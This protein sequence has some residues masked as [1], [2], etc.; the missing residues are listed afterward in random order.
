MA[1]KEINERRRGLLKRVLESKTLNRT[2]KTVVLSA[3]LSGKAMSSKAVEPQVKDAAVD[4]VEQKTEAMPSQRLSEN[5]A[6]LQKFADFPELSPAQAAFVDHT[7]IVDHDLWIERDSIAVKCVDS[8]YVQDLSLTDVACARECKALPKSEQSADGYISFRRDPGVIGSDGKSTYNGIISTDFNA[9]KQSIVLMY[10]SNNEQVAALGRQMINGDHAE[11]AE[12]IR[13]QIYREDGTIVGPE[14]LAKVLNGR[15][16]LSLKGKIMVC[17]AINTAMR[18]LFLQIVYG[19]TQS[20]FSEGGLMIGAGL[21]D[22]GKGL[23]SQVG[24]LYGTLA[25]GPRYLEMAEG[26]IKTIALDE[27]DEICGYEFVHL[28]KFMD[29]IKKGTDAN[30]ALKKVTGT[31]GRFT[32]EQGAV[33]HIDPRQE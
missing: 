28:G 12:R 19:R 7:Y 9:T 6:K 32:A 13:R 4:A 1:E 33:K 22:L 31:Y 23:R 17:D 29:E 24:T 20:A 14:E 5:Y 26:Y 18:E 2:L 30:E 11:T 16:F 3:F 25:K 15:D 10:C 21:E 8:R 27:N